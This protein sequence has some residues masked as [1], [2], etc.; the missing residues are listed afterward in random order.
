[1]SWN[2]NAI[3]IKVG[4]VFGYLT[5][6]KDLGKDEKWKHKIKLCKCI[7]GKEIIVRDTI[8][9]SGKKTSCGCNG[10]YQVKGKR[11]GF[12]TCL[13]NAYHK[14]GRLFVDVI[15]D[16][17]NE[18]TVMLQSLN[19]GATQSCG[20]YNS[21]YL[22]ERVGEKHPLWN[23]N[24]TDE[25]REKNNSRASDKNY[26]IFRK[27]VLKKDDCTCQVCFRKSS[28]NMRV[29]HIC[30]WNSFSH[31]RYNPNNGI[32]LCPTHHDI[33][34][35]DSFH[36]VY[37]NGNNTPEQLEEY[38]NRKRLELGI[39]IRF[40]V[41]EYMGFTPMQTISPITEELPPD[42]DPVTDVAQ[43]Q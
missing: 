27:E 14:N 2:N 28:K 39:D 13:T 40:N 21:I 23:P 10:S 34:Y 25:E 32:I 5:V 16:C 29:H 12:L 24:L 6:M 30:G 33:Q 19:N 7:C 15:C 3:E 1:M 42:L 31:Y 26:R 36:N 41:Y 38:I 8:L 35:D 37:G 43:E 4:D 20:C 17:G 22:S 11:Y 18:K 9:R